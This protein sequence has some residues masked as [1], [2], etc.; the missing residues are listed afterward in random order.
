MYLFVGYYFQCVCLT[1]IYA[2]T[3]QSLFFLAQVRWTEVMVL[4]TE[5][6]NLWQGLSQL[7]DNC[8]TSCSYHAFLLLWGYSDENLVVCR[9]SIKCWYTH[10]NV[11]RLVGSHYHDT[12]YL[13]RRVKCKCTLIF[14][15]GLCRFVTYTKE[16]FCNDI[17]CP[18]LFPSTQP[19][20]S[21]CRFMTLENNITN[22]EILYL[23]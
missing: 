10:P 14:L 23:V 11:V 9:M 3:S 19:E 13:H 12:S 20:F 7:L 6:Q 17:S 15:F 22:I 5:N 21:V 1:L 16:F 2:R 18:W 8:F 4:W